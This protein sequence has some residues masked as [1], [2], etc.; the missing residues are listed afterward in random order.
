MGLIVRKCW[1]G[2]IR[3]W[4]GLWCWECRLMLSFFVFCLLMSGCGLGI[5]ILLYWMSDW[6]ILLCGWCLMM[7]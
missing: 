4:C 7:C 6:L 5:W 3:C 1:I 2:W